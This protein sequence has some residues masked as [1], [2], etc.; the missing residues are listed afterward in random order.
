MTTISTKSTHH[1][2]DN[3]T[4]NINTIPIVN[5]DD[6]D[7]SAPFGYSRLGVWYLVCANMAQAVQQALELDDDIGCAV[8]QQGSLRG[9]VASRGG[10]RNIN[11]R[12][13]RSAPDNQEEDE[14]PVV[15]KAAATTGYSSGPNTHGDAKTAVQN[16]RQMTADVSAQVSAQMEQWLG[17]DQKQLQLAHQHG[18][19]TVIRLLDYHQPK[20]EVPP[21]VDTSG[22]TLVFTTGAIDVQDPD[23]V[24][25]PKWHRLEPHPRNGCFLFL[26]SHLE[27]RI[28]ERLQ[29]IMVSP[30]SASG[31]SSKS[32]VTR[33][34][35]PVHRVQSSEC[36]A[37]KAATI[38]VK[39]DHAWPLLTAGK[40]DN[41]Q[42]EKTTVSSADELFDHQL[43]WDSE[44]YAKLL[45]VKNCIPSLQDIRDHWTL[46]RAIVDGYCD[47]D[48]NYD[49]SYRL[50]DVADQG[51]W[52]L[53]ILRYYA[54]LELHRRYP[55][56][57]K[58]ILPPRVIHHVW[59]SHQLQPGAYKADCQHLL[60][61]N[62]LDHDNRRFHLNGCPRFHQLWRLAYGTQW[63]SPEVIQHEVKTSANLLPP[64]GMTDCLQAN[65]VVGLDS[66]VNL[67]N[68]VQEDVPGFL[69]SLLQ[70]QGD[71]SCLQEAQENFARFLLAA[72]YASTKGIGIT[73]GAVNDLFW[74]AQ[75]TDPHGYAH[76]MEHL[77]SFVDHHPCGKLC[78]PPKD[79]QWLQMT[80]RVWM[81]LYGVGV[82]V[83]GHGLYC[84]SP[85][86]SEGKTPRP[87]G[88][89]TQTNYS[90]SS[91]GVFNW[92][93]AASSRN[94]GIDSTA[95]ELGC[96]ELPRMELV[97]H[98]GYRTRPRTGTIGWDSTRLENM[99]CDGAWKR[100]QALLHEDVRQAF[101]EVLADMLMD[102]GQQVLKRPVSPKT[103]LMVQQ[104]YMA[105]RQ[106]LV[107]L[108]S[109][110][111]FSVS[112]EQREDTRL[113]LKFGCLRWFLYS[114]W[115]LEGERGKKK[116]REVAAT[117]AKLR[118]ARASPLPSIQQKEQMYQE[119]VARHSQKF[120]HLYGV[121]VSIIWRCKGPLDNTKRFEVNQHYNGPSLLFRPVSVPLY[122]GGASV[123][124][125]S[126]YGR[127]VKASATADPYPDRNRMV[128]R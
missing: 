92:W 85:E 50:P 110:G 21:H 54:F 17:L 65:L 81:E 24:I 38:H 101:P 1:H 16:L 105:L 118:S 74:H 111:D 91:N 8:Q 23:E 53:Q 9:S 18:T 27:E 113:A 31:G 25:A 60:E 121:S 78:P 88:L 37:R 5:L 103:R 35:A 66:L 104:D 108:D 124:C 73:P 116:H 63:P 58:D 107:V 33:V 123:F 40:K 45:L 28:S 55:K 13:S 93:L 87:K 128:A 112:S 34:V 114:W 100:E 84:C 64:P 120:E 127:W 32:K 106:E 56:E 125:N 22:F 70:T 126:A 19:R 97:P 99:F 95:L 119:V 115:R 46:L 62:I 26:G 44:H 86:E 98:D 47:T 82:D 51:Y 94:F 39:A 14:L 96:S 75:Q 109:K 29:E 20:A 72:S 117:L 42:D 77:P 122:Q 15:N 48:P 59:L 36:G 69:Q 52:Q 76:A 11:L 83:P 57:A 6:D 43:T 10:R 71:N 102:Q 12:A 41:P 89:Y 61:G 80:K 49:H 67:Y 2:N 30:L 68:G 4:V 7:D 3:N 90:G 79:C